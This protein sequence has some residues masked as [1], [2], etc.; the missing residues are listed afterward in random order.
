MFRDIVK[1]ARTHV[2]T[3]KHTRTHTHTHTQRERERE[4]DRDREK[5]PNSQ[6]K[7]SSGAFRPE[8]TFACLRALKPAVANVFVARTSTVLIPS[9]AESTATDSPGF[10]ERAALWTHHRIGDRC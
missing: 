4:R 5:T 9:A 7:E 1:R 10:L 3:Y 6:N 2:H 8:L